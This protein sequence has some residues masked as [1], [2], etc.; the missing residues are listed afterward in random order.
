M[1]GK[2]GGQSV[3]AGWCARHKLTV[4]VNRGG[5][6]SVKHFHKEESV[7]TIRDAIMPKG[8]GWVIYGPTWL[9]GE[10]DVA[11]GWDCGEGY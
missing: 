6:W 9:N 10:Q 5:A 1:S 4:M 11:S 3:C 8:T 2:R 7:K